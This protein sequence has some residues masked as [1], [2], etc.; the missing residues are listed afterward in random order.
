VSPLLP[1]LS[2]LNRLQG[3]LLR[4]QLRQLVLLPLFAAQPRSNL[5]LHAPLPTQLPKPLI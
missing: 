3:Q 4:A 5:P 2:L 1:V